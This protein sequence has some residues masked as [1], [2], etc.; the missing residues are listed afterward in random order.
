MLASGKTE[1]TMKKVLVLQLLAVVVAIALIA[2]AAGPE[3]AMTVE[4]YALVSDCSGE[5]LTASTH[6]WQ[7]KTF[8][9]SRQG[10]DAAAA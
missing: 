8:A 5:P 9:R 3:V 4:R 7:P 2:A 1:C 6:H 10:C